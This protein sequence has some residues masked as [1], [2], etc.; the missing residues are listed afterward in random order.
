MV[1]AFSQYCINN[2]TNSFT[3]KKSLDISINLLSNLEYWTSAA[4]LNAMSAAS[5]NKTVQVQWI[6]RRIGG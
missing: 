3:I 2:I 5:G 6:E 4:D 1:L